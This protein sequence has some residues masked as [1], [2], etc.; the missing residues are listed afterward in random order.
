MTFLAGWRLLLLVV[1]IA[2]LVAY[3]VRSRRRAGVAARFSSVDL[4][5]S[6]LPRRSGWQRHLPWAALIAAVAVGAVTLAQPA[7]AMRTPKER[8]TIMLTLDTSASLSADDVSPSRFAAAQQSAR[9][10]VLSLPATIQVG[11]VTF[12]RNARLAMPPTTDRAALLGAIDAMRMGT[13]TGTGSGID[14]ALDAIGGVPADAEGK[15][16]PAAVV[17]MS[18]GSPTYGSGNLTPEESV[19]EASTRAK[20]EGIPITTI[21]F[22]TDDGTVVV[23]GETIP[24]PY[25]PVAMRAIAEATGGKTF[26]A[27]SASEL[28]EVYGEIGGSVGY[29]LQT[30]E[31]TVAFAAI[32]FLLMALAAVAALVWSQ[33]LA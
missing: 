23:Q 1:P 25:D 16:A 6:V 8:A 5:A 30:V 3:V 15:R 9:D 22:G 13:G 21:A 14:L 20:S 11:L 12:D 17:L 10:F 33:Q 7:L 28:S 31:I 26:T 19:V 27:E 32:A 29:D 18:D 24:V 2:L 4:L